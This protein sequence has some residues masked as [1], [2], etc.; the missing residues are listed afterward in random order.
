[1]KGLTMKC[2]LESIRRKEILKFCC[3]LFDHKVCG[4]LV[5]RGICYEREIEGLIGG[6]VEGADLDRQ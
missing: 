2:I 5:G 1:M 4:E 3:C 6:A